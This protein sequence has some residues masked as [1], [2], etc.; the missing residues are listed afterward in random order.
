MATQAIT[1]PIV[2]AVNGT[3]DVTD[4]PKE[5]D[6]KKPLTTEEW[7]QRIIMRQNG[8]ASMM[9]DDCWDALMAM[10]YEDAQG[11][12]RMKKELKRKKVSYDQSEHGST[13]SEAIEVTEPYGMYMMYEKVNPGTTWEECQAAWKSRLAN[14]FMDAVRNGQVRRDDRKIMV[15][16]HDGSNAMTVLMT[17]NQITV[18]DDTMKDTLEKYGMRI[19]VAQTNPAGASSSNDQQPTMTTTDQGTTAT[20]S[21]GQEPREPPQ[22]GN[23]GGKRGK[24]GRDDQ[25]KKQKQP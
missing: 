15:H 12:E 3:S 13:D 20:T 7:K 9:E 17:E 4:Q 6:Q 22:G 16:L 8:E 14:Q 1:K 11:E 2:L 10:A 19:T 5:Q 25:D 21:Q 24:D 23:Q 18:F